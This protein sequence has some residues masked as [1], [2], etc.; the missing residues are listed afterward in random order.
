MKKTMLPLVFLTFITAGFCRAGGPENGPYPPDPVKKNW[1]NFS[2]LLGGK[3]QS[4]TPEKRLSNTGIL[5]SAILPGSGEIYAGQKVKGVLFLAAEAALWYGVIS[6][7]RTGMDWEDTYHQYADTHWSREEWE[8][9]YNP[10]TDPSTHELPED[11]E[12]NIVKTQQYYEMIGKYDQFKQGWDDWVTGGPDLT[13]HR[14]EYETMRNKSNVALKNAAYCS[15]VVMANHLISALDTGF[16]IRKKNAA[17]V[18]M[19]A[20]LIPWRN[21]VRPGLGARL[22]W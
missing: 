12:G 13:A 20:V 10:E 8:Q 19:S 3:D 2:T 16:V 5:F 17:R 21:E 1:T 4:T 7:H 11:D 15:M 6:F 9:Y 22:E 14:D 18:T